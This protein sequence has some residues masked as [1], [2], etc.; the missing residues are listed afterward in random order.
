MRLFVI[1]AIILLVSFLPLAAQ[2]VLTGKVIDVDNGEPLAFTQVAVMTTVDSLLV[3]GSTTSEEGVFEIT[4]DVYGD[5]LLRFSYVG[6]DDNWLP[7]DL[8]Q[9]TTDLGRIEL[10]PTVTQLGEVEVSAAAMLFRSEADRRIF[11]VE[12]MT[13]AEGGTAI[14][15]LETLPSVQIDEEGGL[16]MRGSGNIL[17]YINGR[18]SNL[19]S[20]DTES[21][22]EQYPANAIKEVELITNPSSRYEAEG[23]G[24]IIN[25]V[26]REERLQGFN[27]QV[28]LSTGT[29]NKYTGGVNMNYRQNRWNNFL[30]YSY[31][32]RENWEQTESYREY[33]SEGPSPFWTQDF[34]TENLNQSHLLR[35]GLEYDINRSSSLQLFANMNARSRDRERTYN[36]FNLGVLQELD[37]MFIRNLTEDQSRINYEMGTGYSWGD[38][39]GR[40]LFTQV[41][42]AWDNQDRIEYFDETYYNHAMVE[43]TGRSTD[44]FYERPLTNRM[45]DFRADYETVVGEE[46]L[47]ETGLR[48]TWRFYD[49]EQAYGTFNRMTNAYDEIILNGI[50]INNHFTHDRDIYAAYLTFRNN[51]GSLSYQGGIR[52][53]Y[54]ATETWQKAGITNGFLEQNFEPV[55]DTTSVNNYFGLFPSLFLSYELSPNQDIQASYSRR[56]RRPGTGGMMPFLNAQ[57]FYNLRLGNPYLQPSYTNNFEL[58]YIRAWENFM[59]TGGVFHRHTENGLTRVFVPF[60][61]GSM[62]TWTNANSSNN[63]GIEIINY[64][65]LRDQFDL[66]LT[67]NYF[68]SVVSSE[69]EGLS[70]QNQSYSWSMS[71]FGNVNFPGIVSAQFS[72]NYWG[73]RVIPQGF[74]KP[75]FGMNVGFRRNV[76]NNQGTIGLNVSDVFNSRRFAL[77]TNGSEF[78]QER[79]FYRESRVLTLSFT[80]RFR[81]FRDRNGQQRDDGF[82]GGYE[83]LF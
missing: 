19:S 25:L 30:S 4:T 60:N 53:E 35:Y 45:I 5:I 7:L 72:A 12:N 43:L 18:P 58:N 54:T 79:S 66:T 78:F 69:V 77:E 39:N 73:P 70:Y 11:N 51:Y 81:D 38:G 16:S 55:R 41:S 22:L 32:Y 26:L 20:D 17:I 29:G 44:E 48:A 71:L 9:G 13:V 65:T 76:M 68:Y 31:Q 47:I 33:F 40:S 49:R 46:L 3:T 34:S 64:L 14:Q 8:G 56:I 21:I 37:S 2:N 59:F 42:Y 10:S 52:A 82:D 28:N 83:G 23:V 63:T 50:P 57:D 67:G 74:I 61:Q 62:V 24:G 27:A 1:N 36:T 6:Y 15:V 80:W 75:V